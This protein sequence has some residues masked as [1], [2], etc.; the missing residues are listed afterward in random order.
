M[1][2]S[3]LFMGPPEFSLMNFRLAHLRFAAHLE[4]PGVDDREVLV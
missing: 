1:A 4:S 3:G 2:P